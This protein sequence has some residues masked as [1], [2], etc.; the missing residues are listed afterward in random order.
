LR[1][2]S[3]SQ[4][5]IEVDSQTITTFISRH[6]CAIISSNAPNFEWGLI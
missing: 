4:D 3:S 5:V 2:L 1:E 6:S